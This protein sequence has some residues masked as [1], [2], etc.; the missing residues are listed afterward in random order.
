[1]RKILFVGVFVLSNIFSQIDVSVS[2]A[3]SPK[4]WLFPVGIDVQLSDRIEISNRFSL[5]HIDYPFERPVW[6]RYRRGNYSMGTEISSINYDDGPIQVSFGRDYIDFA[7]GK[8]AGLFLSPRSPALDHIRFMLSKFK[9]VDYNSIVVRLDNREA[10][11]NGDIE[12]ARRWLYL[13]SV[14]IN[15]KNFSGGMIDA[16]L[17]TGFD[18]GLEWYYLAPMSSLFMERKHQYIWRE[19]GDSTSI[20][21]IGDNDNHY[22][23]G[24]WTYVLPNGSIYGE[25]LIDEWQLSSE[26]RPNMQTVFAFLLGINH[27]YA[28]FNLTAE[29]YFGSPWLYL[30]RGLYNTPEYHGL[31]LGLERPDVHGLCFAVNYTVDEDKELHL[32]ARF[33]QSGTQTLNTRWDAWD[34]KM[35][36]F[37]FS[38]TQ[39]PEVSF[40]YIDKQGK[41]FQYLG[42]KHNWLGSGDTHLLIGW[43]YNLT[44]E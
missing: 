29:Y 2:P 1:M 37:S 16:V 12:V 20:I 9:G 30:S 21:G 10:I 17:S 23:G 31:P 39:K 42:L 8:M 7:S 25:W 26:H 22:I 4:S 32:E 11:W 41:Y 44:I 34:N 5:F 40:R 35:P 27:E 15:W 33:S 43:E 13:R 24:Y 18:R 38:K 36:L 6:Y 28:G 3:A 19:G 14:G